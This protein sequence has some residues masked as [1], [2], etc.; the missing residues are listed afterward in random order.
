MWQI[1]AFIISVPS[2][3]FAPGCTMTSLSVTVLKPGISER[4]S[5]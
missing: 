1:I 4:S 5:P 2:V 3:V